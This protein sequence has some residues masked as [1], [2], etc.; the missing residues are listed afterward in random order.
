MKIQSYEHNGRVLILKCKQ[1]VVEIT[2]FAENKIKP[3]Q[4]KLNSLLCL[5]DV[6]EKQQFLTN[7]NIVKNVLFS[8]Q[9]QLQSQ[10]QN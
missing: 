7:D 10:K 8:L 6:R 4:S 9:Q 2:T 3:C 5:N 1:N